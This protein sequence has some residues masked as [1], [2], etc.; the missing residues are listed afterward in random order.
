MITEVLGF[1]LILPFLPLYAQEMG[2]T[3]LMIG[4]LI[5]SFSLFQFI[6][7]PIMGELSDRYGRRP[8]LIISQIS[9]TI[10]FII[11]GLSNQLWMLYLSRIVDGLLGS[12]ATI[13][14]AYIGD[15][16]DKKDRSKAFGIT[17]V[18]FGIGFMIGPAIGG[19]LSRFG[20]S[21]PAFLAAAISLSS[22]ILTYLFLPETVEK[23]GQTKSFSV[24]IIDFKRLTRYFAQDK[25]RLQLIE[26]SFYVLAHSLWA[27]NFSLYAD[28]LFSIDPGQIGFALAY[29]GGINII[30]R[31]L[32]I[33]KLI[34]WFGEA[35]LEKMGVVSLLI[36]LIGASIVS[37]WSGLLFI[38]T[39]FAL[40][41]GM[42][43]PLM[44]GDISRSADENEQGAIMGVTS[45]LN[46]V[47]QIFGPVIGGLML[48][49]LFPQSIMILGSALIFVSGVL[50]FGEKKNY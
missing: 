13:A 29:V 12:N 48:T 4:L 42:L 27:G 31:G 45:S 50:I 22:I 9:T 41:S 7:A 28:M 16:T 40:G 20:Y 11:L 49:H 17:G 3:P 6:S 34:N 39:F 2:A 25:I 14:Q 26:Y 33:P 24:Q 5:T 18:A 1:S 37:S 36:G 15:I 46:S 38:I 10:S 19:W 32:L 30:I 43:R 8:L 35:R 47:S 21:V 23:S 44:M